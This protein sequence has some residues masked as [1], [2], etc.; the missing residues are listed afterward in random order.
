[1]GRVN[2]AFGV[3]FAVTIA[4]ILNSLD[5]MEKITFFRP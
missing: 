4:P 5:M 2:D 1:M 3:G